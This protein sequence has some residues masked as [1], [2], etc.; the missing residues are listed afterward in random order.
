MRNGWPPDPIAVIRRIE[1]QNGNVPIVRFRAVTW[2]PT[3]AARELIGYYESGDDA[4][5]AAW[6]HRAGRHGFCQHDST[7]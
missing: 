1:R 2:E 7:Q 4:A 6:E 5:H 3:S